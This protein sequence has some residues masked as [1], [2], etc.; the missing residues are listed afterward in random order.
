LD[1]QLVDETQHKPPPDQSN[2]PSQVAARVA[3]VADKFS[4]HLQESTT[5]M[6]GTTPK[7]LNS[8]DNVSEDPGM[9]TPV[10]S[11]PLDQHTDQSEGVLEVALLSDSTQHRAHRLQ[12]SSHEHSHLEADSVHKSWFGAI[13]NSLDSNH[14]NDEPQV[15]ETYGRTRSEKLAQVKDMPGWLKHQASRLERY[16]LNFGAEELRNLGERILQNPVFFSTTLEWTRG[17]WELA[18][19][20]HGNIWQVRSV[21]DVPCSHT[22]ARHE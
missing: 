21:L 7:T 19:K 9:L 17:R 20:Q 4:N 2:N 16:D 1:L 3:T 10:C 6:P 8:S 11:Q 5:K 15:A 22:P 13:R 12:G 18:T 14:S